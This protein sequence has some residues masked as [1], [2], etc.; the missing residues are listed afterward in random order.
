MLKWSESDFAE[1]FGVEVD[2]HDAPHTF[3]YE[4]PRDGLRL[5]ITILALEH[6]VFVRLFRDGLPQPVF[7]VRRDLCKHVHITKGAEFRHCFEAGSSRQPVTTDM[8]IPPVLSYGV[9]VYL[10]PQLQVE[11]IQQRYDETA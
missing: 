9:R 2:D 10:E 6:T 11:L 4:V 3:E 1:F 8:G 7:V 5:Q